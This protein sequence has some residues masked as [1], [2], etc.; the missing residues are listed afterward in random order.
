MEVSLRM[1]LC[2]TVSAMYTCERVIGL[3]LVESSSVSMSA[4]NM[5]EI[6][7]QSAV[8]CERV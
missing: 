5:L 8:I 3:Y 4:P 6:R 7:L 2:R 1:I